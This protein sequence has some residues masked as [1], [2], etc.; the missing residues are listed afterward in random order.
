MQRML[1][2]TLVDGAPAGRH[3][4][5]TG[6]GSLLEFA[7]NGA[8]PPARLVVLYGARCDRSLPVQVRERDTEGRAVAV[9]L[10]GRAGGIIRF[11]PLE[12]PPTDRAEAVLLIP[13]A[14]LPSRP[15]LTFVDQAAPVAARRAVTAA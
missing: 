11:A 3:W 9:C 2:F 6:A 4:M 14:Q 5:R 10:P 8:V 1:E 13:I 7:H 12:V 15:T